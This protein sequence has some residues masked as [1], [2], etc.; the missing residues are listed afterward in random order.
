VSVSTL[1]TDNTALHFLPHFTTDDPIYRLDTSLVLYPP[2]STNHLFTPLPQQLV[3][4]SPLPFK[5][6]AANSTT[7]PSVFA[8]SQGMECP[9]PKGGELVD[10]SPGEIVWYP[11][12]G[13]D[14]ATG[15]WLKYRCEKNT[16]IYCALV[17]A[18][19]IA[20]AILL[21][22]PTQEFTLTQV[23][24]DPAAI[25][26]RV[27]RWLRILRKHHPVVEVAW[28]AELNPERTLFHVHGFL[29]TGRTDA[30]VSKEHMAE[31]VQ[32]ADVGWRFS[33][34][35]V[36]RHRRKLVSHYQYPMK[37]LA[38]PE[39]RSIFLD[40]NRS[41][42]RLRLIQSSNSFWR[43]GRNGERL[44]LSEAKRYSYQRSGAWRR[45]AA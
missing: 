43:D 16:C 9:H 3:I 24:D 45:I 29:H 21:A 33:I 27:A 39:L 11:S 40:L 8:A 1:L 41:P 12:P 44:T 28:A 18:G 14:S 38:D 34:G 22:E 42:E 10:Y 32:K 25:K 13:Q 7:I 15:E 23:G 2:S 19:R 35:Q 36:P 6:G 37:T 5:R 30:V 31:A 4:S 20:G 17:N 26:A